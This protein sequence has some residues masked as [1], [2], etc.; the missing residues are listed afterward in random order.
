MRFIY[1]MLFISSYTFLH[2][3][4]SEENQIK[5]LRSAIGS[6]PNNAAV[7]YTEIAL[8]LLQLDRLEEASLECDMALKEDPSYGKAHYCRGRLLYEALE[9]DSAL[10]AYNQAIYK[11]AGQTAFYAHRGRLYKQM[12]R[13]KDAEADYKKAIQLDDPNSTKD[14]AD[15]VYAYGHRGNLYYY[16]G[17][18]DAATVDF[19]NAVRKDSNAYFS[20]LKLGVV[21][22]INRNYLESIQLLEK[23]IPIMKKKKKYDLIAEAYVYIGKNLKA[24]GKNYSR[25]IK[26][27]LL[28]GD[29]AI[30]RARSDRGYPNFIKGTALC[31]NDDFNRAIREFGKAIALRDDDARIYIA[32]ANAY[33]QRAQMFYK[34]GEL[35]EAKHD[36]EEALT[37]YQRAEDIAEIA[38]FEEYFKLNTQKLM[39]NVEFSLIKQNV[40][41][42][43]NDQDKILFYT[44]LIASNP[45]VDSLYLKR[46]NLYQG[47]HEWEEALADYDKVLSLT[48]GSSMAWYEKG[49]TRYDHGEYEL[50]IQ[51]YSRAIRLDPNNYLYY[52]ARGKAFRQIRKTEDSIKDYKESLR[53]N[54]SY[55]Y[56][57]NNLGNI[58]L[59][60]EQYD[61]ART[62][63]IKALKLSQSKN[64]FSQ[65]KLAEIFFMDG[66]HQQSVEYLTYC[67]PQ[68]EK[69]QK[70]DLL[71]EAYIFRQKNERILKKNATDSTFLVKAKQALDLALDE[72]K[73]DK[74]YVYMLRGKMYYEWDKYTDAINELTKA[75]ALRRD[76]ARSYVERGNCYFQLLNLIKRNG[77]KE[78]IEHHYSNAKEDYQ[79]A[80]NFLDVRKDFVLYEEG[81]VI[82]LKNG[83]GADLMKSVAYFFAVDKYEQKKTWSELKNPIKDALAIAAELAEHYNFDTVIIRNPTLNQINDVI[84]ASH[85]KLGGYG[86][87]DQVLFFFSGHGHYSD[88]TKEGFLVPT[89]AKESELTYF[90]FSRLGDMLDK[91]P[92]R[93][94]FSIIDVCFS[95]TFFPVIATKR[96]KEPTWGHPFNPDEA[97]EER[98]SYIVSALEYKSRKAL[99]S[100][101]KEP[102][103]DGKTHSPFAGRLL[104]VLRQRNNWKIISANTIKAQVEGLLPNPRLGSFG[105]DE[106]G[107]EFLFIPKKLMD[108]QE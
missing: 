103:S 65:L 26:S 15:I 25:S 47:L 74:S 12:A 105:G 40:P 61:S 9:Y 91:H 67:I 88:D 80:V 52:G 60:N 1:L 14:D 46:G 86:Q 94:V 106:P 21:N 72:I 93:H 87:Y 56:V 17:K 101:G 73:G 13:F 100:S 84:K 24:Q 82:D 69:D 97:F 108:N 5:Q 59:Y 3:Q 41:G 107:G 90:P 51:D 79:T 7:Y 19:S 50:S 75:I 58:F 39:E 4:L 81:H 95:G 83:R 89:D 32:R 38:R 37:D 10:E 102:V 55:D 48:P 78:E 57:I 28:Y 43:Q 20:L 92:C 63:Y 31:M 71:G 77:R 98:L 96:N 22:H 66:N 68:F 29:T 44:R 42:I 23:A 62:Y 76:D 104:E 16:Y 27:A 11:D 34:E 6:N 45:K 18:I 70:Y 49:N 64:S 35:R 30:L 2:A 99:T 33:F 36:C 54:P 53:I 8:L 85:K